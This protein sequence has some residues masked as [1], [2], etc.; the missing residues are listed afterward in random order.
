MFYFFLLRETTK[1]IL[2]KVQRCN[3]NLKDNLSYQHLPLNQPTSLPGYRGSQ[4][5]LCTMYMQRYSVYTC[6]TIHHSDCSTVVLKEVGFLF[7][8]LSVCLLAFFLLYSPDWPETQ[9]HLASARITAVWCHS[10]HYS[11]VMSQPALQ[12]VMP[13]PALQ[14]VYLINMPWLSK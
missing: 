8:C 2:L 11:C 10:Q 14:N 13:Q 3:R 5:C 4:C 9:D 12:Y 6:L 1:C 7:V